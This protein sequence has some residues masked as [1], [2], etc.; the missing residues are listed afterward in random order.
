[1]SKG[2]APPCYPVRIEHLEQLPGQGQR[3]TKETGQHVRR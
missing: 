1:M 3:C 2:G